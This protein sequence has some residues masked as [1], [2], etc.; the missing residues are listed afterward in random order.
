LILIKHAYW[1]TMLNF[2]KLW[3]VD[4]WKHMNNLVTYIFYEVKS[5]NE[6]CLYVWM[7]MWEKDEILWVIMDEE[8][9]RN[10]WKMMVCVL[11]W[12]SKPRKIWVLMLINLRPRIDIDRGIIWSISFQRSCSLR[13]YLSNESNL[14]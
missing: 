3:Y 2:I 9:K 14:A 11:K 4:T 1:E 5:L 13:C 8:R 7:L 12:T 10:A 6:L